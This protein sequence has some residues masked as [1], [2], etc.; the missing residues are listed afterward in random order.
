M[1]GVGRGTFTSRKLITPL[2]Q[3]KEREKS[4]P[5][6][7][8]CNPPPFIVVVVVIV[9]NSLATSKAEVTLASCFGK[10]I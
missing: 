9:V 4:S 5:L 7:H 10:I 6:S 2:L 3:N 8:I 1:K